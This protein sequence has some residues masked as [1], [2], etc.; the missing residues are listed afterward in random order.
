MAKMELGSK[1]VSHC[2]ESPNGHN[3]ETVAKFKLLS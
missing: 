2:E 3:V 1:I